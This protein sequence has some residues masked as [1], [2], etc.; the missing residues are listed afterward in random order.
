MK[1]S[2]FITVSCLSLVLGGLAYQS[3]SYAEKSENPLLISQNTTQD[4]SVTIEAKGK[5]LLNLFFAQKF[6]P[7]LNTVSPQLREEISLELLQ[8]FWNNTNKQNGAFK[9]IKE[10]KVIITPA[11]DL[12]IFTLEFEKVTED[13]IVIFSDAEEIIGIDIPTADSIDDIAKN[14]INDLNNGDFANARLHL[15]PFLKEQIFGEQLESRWN[16][17]KTPLGDFKEIKSTTVRR[18]TRGDDTDVVFMN[19]EFAQGEEQIL[20]I[21]NDSK[22]IIG[23]DFIQ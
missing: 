22:S 12:A 10:S 16:S 5:E 21:F 13:W 2:R 11:S 20:I 15:H 4:K 3:S 17:F 23:V 6:Q 18:G 19:L 14:F 9:T 7:V 1:I 8:R